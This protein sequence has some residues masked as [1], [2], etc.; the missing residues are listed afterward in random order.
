MINFQPSSFCF[1]GG[2][3]RANAGAIPGIFSGSDNTLVISPVNAIWRFSDPDIISADIHAARAVQ[4]IIVSI[5]P[6]FENS[7]VFI[8]WRKH[9]AMGRV[10]RAK[11]RERDRQRLVV[12]GEEAREKREAK[13]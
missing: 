12:R 6:L 13:E 11:G 7:A 8:V 4:G 9:H 1:Y 2:C 10:R 3:T 5:D